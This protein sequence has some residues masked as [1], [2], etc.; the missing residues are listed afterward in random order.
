MTDGVIRLRVAT[1]QDADL[2]L[3]W[4]NDSETRRASHNTK[5]VTKEQHESW[6]KRALNDPTRKLLIAEED[7]IPVGTVRAELTAGIYEL[8]WTLSPDAR[9]HGLAKRMV[10][11]LAGQISDPIRA[12]VKCGNVASAKIAEYAGMEFDRNDNGVLHYRRGALK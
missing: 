1:I 12:E 6:L 2:L 7:G 11:E 8:S 9:G 3:D 5:I 10:A 4:R